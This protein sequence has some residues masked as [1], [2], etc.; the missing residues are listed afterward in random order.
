MILRG[1]AKYNI[2]VDYKQYI[3]LYWFWSEKKG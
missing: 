2:S 1:T 3:S